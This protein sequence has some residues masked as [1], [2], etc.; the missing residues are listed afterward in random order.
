[1]FEFLFKYPL[2]F[3]Q[4]GSLIMALPWWQF[5][6]L[7][8]GVLL[9]AFIALGYFRLRGRTE[10]KHRAVIALL[11]SLAI[12]LIIFSLLRPLLEVS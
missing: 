4:R 11:R 12:S 10:I 6:L 9:L 5:A 7:P 2:E 1:M 3:F 8:L